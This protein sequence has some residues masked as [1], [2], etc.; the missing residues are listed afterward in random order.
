[1]KFTVKH[2]F[3]SGFNTFENGNSHDSDN[4]PEMTESDLNRWYQAGFIDIDG[5][6]PGPDAKP[7]GNPELEVQNHKVNIAMDDVAAKSEGV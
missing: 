2:A 3:K 7:S 1:M 4:F 5:Y 6:D